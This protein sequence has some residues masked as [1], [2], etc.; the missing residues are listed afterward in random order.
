[1][2]QGGAGENVEGA[3]FDAFMDRLQDGAGSGEGGLAM[4]QEALA[5]LPLDA[6]DGLKR[7]FQGLLAV[8]R[9][10]DDL[11]ER[12]REAARTLLHGARAALQ[13]GEVPDDLA[14]GA[15]EEAPELIALGER[16]SEGLAST[17]Q[18][19]LWYG[20]LGETL[21]PASFRRSRDEL[22]ASLLEPEA[23]ALL[24]GA[25]PEDRLGVWRFYG[26]PQTATQI[27]EDWTPGRGGEGGAG[28]ASESPHDG[29]TITL[30]QVVD[31]SPGQGPAP[32]ALRLPYSPALVELTT[33]RWPVE[34][35]EMRTSWAFVGWRVVR[36][37]L[38]L[39]FS[40]VPLTDAELEHLTARLEREGV[41]HEPRDDVRERAILEA[42]VDLLL[43]APPAARG[44]DDGGLAPG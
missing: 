5:S 22:V 24:P 20:M 29:E 27:L 16:L 30:A 21:W 13:A 37:E 32:R 43:A 6:K 26:E 25:R 3:I 17:A 44:D 8:S 4:V 33:D 42:T 10:S 38:P 1:V 19:L 39:F 28:G 40:L 7:L 31:E 11:Q 34:D 36:E 35:G 18:Y 15:S 23:R 9:K 2:D 14:R 41:R 12:A